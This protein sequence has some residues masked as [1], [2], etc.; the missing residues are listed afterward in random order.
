M[1]VLMCFLGPYKYINLSKLSCP[2][3]QSCKRAP[4]AAMAPGSAPGFSSFSVLSKPR[5][6]GSEVAACKA[7]CEDADSSLYELYGSGCRRRILEPSPLN[8][9]RLL[10][11][12]R[13]HDR[14]SAD[15]LNKKDT[16]L[17]GEP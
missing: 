12:V 14:N 2:S 5:K 16:A 9:S 6:F 15:L 7:W 1:L 10:Q 4:E 11:I 13:L 17:P 8:E 3:G